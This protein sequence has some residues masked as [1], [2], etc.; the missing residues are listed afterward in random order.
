MKI[1]TKKLEKGF[2][3]RRPLPASILCLEDTIVNRAQ[4]VGYSE[5]YFGFRDRLDL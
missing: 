4:E 1:N 5:A 2:L 3:S